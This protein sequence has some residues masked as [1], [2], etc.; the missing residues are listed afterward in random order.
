MDDAPTDPPIVVHEPQDAASP[1]RRV[2]I[3]HITVGLA[4][5]MA[6]LLEF[7]RRAGLEEDFDP[8]DPELVSWRG[9]GPDIWTSK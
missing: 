3:K 7:A 6:D 1:Y 9:G 8:L 4:H 5:G 2:D